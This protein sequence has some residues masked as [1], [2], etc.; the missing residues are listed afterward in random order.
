MALFKLISM[1]V[2]AAMIAGV[3]APAF[4]QA[5]TVETAVAGCASGGDCAALVRAVLANV[6][7]ARRAAVI[8]DLAAQLAEIPGAGANVAAGIEAAAEFSADPGQREQLANLADTVSSN[9]G[10]GNQNNIDTETAASGG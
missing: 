3:S 2:A 10:G 9:T 5:Q 8:A 6:P 4:S 1:G 7:A